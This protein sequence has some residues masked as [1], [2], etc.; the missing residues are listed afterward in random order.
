MYILMYFFRL[1]SYVYRTHR[2][3]FPRHTA[4]ILVLDRHYLYYF[5]IFIMWAISNQLYINIRT[6]ALFRYHAHFKNDES[7]LNPS[8]YPALAFTLHMKTSTFPLAPGLKLFGSFPFVIWNWSPITSRN[9]SSFKA[10][11][12]STLLPKTTIGLEAISGMFK[13]PSNSLRASGNLS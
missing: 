10:S 2:E 12:L 11:F 1:P 6:N 13:I 5:T 9:Y 4:A 7:Q 3:S 8:E